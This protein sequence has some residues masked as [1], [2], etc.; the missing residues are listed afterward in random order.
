VK[1]RFNEYPA[2]FWREIKVLVPE[3]PTEE[4]LKD[5]YEKISDFPT[6]YGMI[7]DFYEAIQLIRKDPKLSPEQ[8]KKI[9]ERYLKDTETMFECAK[10]LGQKMDEDMGTEEDTN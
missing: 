8:L 3:V 9:I 10:R 2:E 6:M 4:D 5:A 1:N 7:E